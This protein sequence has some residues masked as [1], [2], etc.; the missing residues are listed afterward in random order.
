MCSVRGFFSV[1]VDNLKIQPFISLNKGA[2]MRSG[3]H[4][5]LP[6]VQGGKR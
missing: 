1:H 3:G 2:T 4:R 5:E 6:A